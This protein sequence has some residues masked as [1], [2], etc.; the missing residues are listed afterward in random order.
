M[1][2]TDTFE[3]E[4]TYFFGVS[5]EEPV[6]EAYM[7]ALQQIDLIGLGSVDLLEQKMMPHLEKA[8]RSVAVQRKWDFDTR[9][10]AKIEFQI[11]YDET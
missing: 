8:Y 1:S 10:A 5:D 7:A 11:I 6:I 2:E 3:Q 9:A 4:L